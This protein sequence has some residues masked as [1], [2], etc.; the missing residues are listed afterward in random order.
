MKLHEQGM[1]AGLNFIVE[2]VSDNIAQRLILKN[3]SENGKVTIQEAEFFKM[4]S[5]ELLTE[6]SDDLIPD[7][8]DDQMVL[9]DDQ[10]NQYL[11]HSD[12]GAL[13]MLQGDPANTEDAIAA[14]DETDQNLNESAIL[15]RK[16]LKK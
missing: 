2:S 12:T 1:G 11:Y 13:E 16:L 5:K 8:I 9:T 14:P 10:G 7:E 15:A 6:G 4:L 3:L